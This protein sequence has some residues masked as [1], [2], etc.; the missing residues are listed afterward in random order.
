MKRQALAAVCGLA[1]LVGLVGCGGSGSG[2][3]TADTASVKRLCP[4]AR[5]AE[6]HYNSV[7]EAMGLQFTKKSV[8]V[9]TRKAAEALL[10][11]VQRLERVGSAFQHSGIRSLEFT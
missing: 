10:L 11:E 2:S 6:R 1:G 5:S 8:E 9:P 4:Q 7:A 3:G